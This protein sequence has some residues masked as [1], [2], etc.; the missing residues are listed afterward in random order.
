MSW[1]SQ[2]NGDSVS[3]LME[4]DSPGVRYLALR[5]LMDL[6]ED[7]PELKRARKKAH[8]EGPIP[9]ILSHMD[10][11]GYWARPGVGY[12]PKYRSTVWSII[13]LAQLGASIREDKRLNRACQYLLDQ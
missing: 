9:K 1:K 8:K 2:L 11:E 4:P 7:D 3:W 13:M 12:G 6:Q 5:D 10:E